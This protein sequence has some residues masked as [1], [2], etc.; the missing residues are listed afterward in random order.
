MRDADNLAVVQADFRKHHAPTGH[1]EDQIKEGLEHDP[2]AKKIISLAKDERARIFWLK[3]DM[4][5]T[6]GN[7]LYVP[8]W[9]DL[10]SA[11]FDCNPSDDPVSLSN[12]SALIPK[13]SISTQVS[14]YQSLQYG[15]Q[16]QSQQY[17]HTQSS[18]PLSI[19]YPPNEFQSL[20]HHNVY[21]PSSSIPQVEYASSVN[22]QPDFSQP[23]SGLIVLVFQ[24]GNDPIDAISH[25]MSF[26]T[27]VVTSRYPPTNI[28]LRNSSNPPQEQQA[29]INNGRV[30]VQ[31]IQGRHTSL[32]AGTSR[33]YTSGA[34][35]N[36]FRKQKTVICYN[37][38]GEGY[39]SK[40]CT[41]PKRKRDESW[42]KDKVLLVIITHN[43][44][45]QA[46]DLDAYDSDC[47]EINT[48]KVALMANLSH[49]G[50]D[51][52]AEVHNHDNVNHNLINQAVQAMLLFKQSN[53]VNQS[54][55]EITSDINII[56]YSQCVSES[57][58]EAI[59]NFNSPT[60]QDALILSVIERLKTQVVNCTRINLDN[61]SVNDTLT[62]E[63]ERY[64][65]QKTNAIVICDSEETLMLAEESRSKMLLKQKDPMMSEK[66]VNTKSVDYAVFNQL[67]QDFETQFAPQTEL[68]AEQAFSS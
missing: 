49:Y 9:G 64:K 46:D 52:L 15:S 34:S 27:A 28:Q 51:D 4:L 8:K 54:K 47:D 61:K 22:Q 57:Q 21:T 25:M 17:S 68:S 5:F 24:K 44:A 36:N 18:T 20:V 12:S 29:T 45:Y 59:Q 2:L 39:M 42:F 16:Y 26:L 40:Q 19:T 35:E 43:A 66:K 32:A 6:K 53:I 55:T 60:Q 50:S 41:K 62:A 30:T 56:P 63:L 13:H 3:G 65:D 33:T 38:K 10:R 58:Q 1:L 67:S 7:R 31:P 11:C 48:A 37:C 23:D 14:S